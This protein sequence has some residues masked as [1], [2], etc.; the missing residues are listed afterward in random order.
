M[1]DAFTR[2]YT[3]WTGQWVHPDSSAGFGGPGV[4][5]NAGVLGDWGDLDLIAEGRHPWAPGWIQCS[6]G[7][8]AAAPPQMLSM[9]Q[10]RA[11]LSANEGRV[12][13]MYLDTKG[14]VTVG[15]GTMLPD[16]K[17]A[18]ALH[19]LVRST[20]AAASAAEIETEFKA[21][22]AQPAGQLAANYTTLLDMPEDQIDSLLDTEITTREAGLRMQF[23]GYD[24]YPASARR[25]LIDMVFNLG[26]GSA[27][28]NTGLLA[29]KTMKTAIET[30]DWKKAAAS[31][32]RNGPS[33]SRNDWT[34]DRFLESAP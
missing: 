5:R 30:G 31:C 24:G 7:A 32:H 14:L 11:D 27:S 29:F 4:F 13:H 9:A 8:G 18:Q 17:A 3:G 10:V 26:M 25:A 6:L 28:K 15:V 23:K 20:K 2:M 19:F 12:N 22:L 33:R 34:R 21:V 1:S 16:V